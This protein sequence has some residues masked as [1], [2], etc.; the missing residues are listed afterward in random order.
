MAWRWCGAAGGRL[1]WRL[2]SRSI[3]L[4]AR[5]PDASISPSRR[6]GMLDPARTGR[7]GLAVTS[8]YGGYLVLGNGLPS[9]WEWLRGV[10]ACE[11]EEYGGG[12]KVTLA[13]RRRTAAR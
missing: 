4:A 9:C 2:A 7:G 13:P 10:G 3:L 11:A 5:G 12:P 1:I 6:S 8:G